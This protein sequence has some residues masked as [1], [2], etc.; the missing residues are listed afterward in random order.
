MQRSFHCVE[1]LDFFIVRRRGVKFE[2][3]ECYVKRQRLMDALRY[4]IEMDKYYKDVEID[5]DSVA[6][7]LERPTNLSSK[8]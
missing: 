7:L 8:L 6:F 1:E 4:K 5:M 3:C 2:Y